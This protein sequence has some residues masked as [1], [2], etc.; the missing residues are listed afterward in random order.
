[1][2]IGAFVLLVLAMAAGFVMW[3]S[4]TRERRDQ[5]RYEIYFRGSVSGLSE[6]GTVR[7]LGV[8]VGRVS[9]IAIDERDAGRVKVIADIYEGTPITPATVARLTAQ[10]LTGL[11]FID[12]KLADPARGVA[13]PVPGVKYPVIPSEQSEFDVFV[14]SLPDLVTRAT[15]VLSRMNALLSDDNIR[16]TNS[17]LASLD[18]ASRELPPLTASARQLVAD[19]GHAAVDVKAAAADIR[20]FT[21][22]STPAMNSA[23]ARLAQLTTDLAS[24]SARLDRFVAANDANVSRFTG[25]GL[26]EIES[27]V[28]ESR[29]AA[30]EVRSLARSLREDPSQLVYQPKSTGVEV[31]P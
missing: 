29:D 11:L 8:S 23:A 27:L 31:P 26:R 14:S 1:V 21:G 19:L 2:T 18:R 4:D 5:T 3:Y 15:E 9:R 22:K 16:S 10:G 20:D 13:Q 7:Y 6:G 24:A 28:R 25:E 30:Q 12:L 17:M